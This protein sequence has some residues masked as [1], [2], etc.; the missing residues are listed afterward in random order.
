MTVVEAYRVVGR[1]AGDPEGGTLPVRGHVVPS[2]GFLVGG[3]W[4]PLVFEP[5]QSLDPER[6][7]AFVMRL[8]TPY[9]G[10]WTDSADGRLYVDGSDWFATREAAERVAR[11]RGEIAF[12]DV[13]AGCEVR[14][15]G[16]ESGVG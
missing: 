2:H 14:L 15:D 9:V 16:G 6:L 1:I 4:P 12:W 7:V 10:W 11:A 5:G 13:S 8:P 3:G